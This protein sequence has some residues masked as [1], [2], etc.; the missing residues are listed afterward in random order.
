[1]RWFDRSFPADVP[2]WMVPNIVERLRGTP[3]PLEE[4]LRNVPT[5]IITRRWNDTWSM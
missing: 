1:M 5:F 4:L 2:S 3:A